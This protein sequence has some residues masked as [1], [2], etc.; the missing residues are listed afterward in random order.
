M[1]ISLYV[2]LFLNKLVAKPIKIQNSYL[3]ILMGH[4]FSP[5]IIFGNFKGVNSGKTSY[6]YQAMTF[7]INDQD[8]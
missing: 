8:R 5:S 1:L 2:Q 6:L 3:C 4:T 7:Q